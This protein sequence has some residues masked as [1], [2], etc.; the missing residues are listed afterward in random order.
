MK[1]TVLG[2]GAAGGMPSINSG[3]GLA[4][5]TNPRNRRLRQSILVEQGK[6]VILVDTSPDLRQQMLDTGVRRL[7][8]VLYTHAHADHVHGIDDLREIN[9]AMNGPIDCYG[10]SE[11]MATIQRKFDYVFKDAHQG[12]PGHGMSRVVYRPWLV[13]HEIDGPFRIGEVEIDPYPQDHGFGQTTLGFRFG[14]VAY[15]T[16]VQ[17]FSEDVLARLGG[18]DLWLVSCLSD[19]AHETHAHVDKVLGWVARVRPKLTVL[20]HMGPRLD[21]ARLAATLP[22]G[23]VPA[24]DGMVIEV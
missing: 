18:L 15:S 5:P 4:D 2:C 20:I 6:T 11:T 14:S 12:D 3:W 16:D 17:Q 22:E 23:V 10:S 9:R 24:Y 7:D 21:Y 19:R 8:G 1:V 13:P